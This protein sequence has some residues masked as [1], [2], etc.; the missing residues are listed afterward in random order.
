MKEPHLQVKFLPGACRTGTGQRWWVDAV[1]ERDLV[2]EQFELSDGSG[3]RL[4]VARYYTPLG[5]SIQKSYKNGIEA[6]NKDL[7][8]R[9]H[10]G[11]MSFC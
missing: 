9:F 11:E 3:L 2:Q 5:R 1:L 7:M 6:Y 4:T 8:N 10:N